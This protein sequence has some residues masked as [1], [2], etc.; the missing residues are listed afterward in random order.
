MLWASRIGDQTRFEPMVLQLEVNS[1]RARLDTCR[2]EAL[3]LALG[4][5]VF[6]TDRACRRF[7]VVVTVAAMNIS[8]LVC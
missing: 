5:G 4:F 6:I 7:W 3:C 8:R 2:K 1:C